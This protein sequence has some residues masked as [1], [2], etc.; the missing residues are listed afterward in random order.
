ML[1]DLSLGLFSQLSAD[2][3]SEAFL[4]MISGFFIFAIVTKNRFPKL[5]SITSN[6]LT[7]LGIL[8]TFTGVVI[9]LLEFDVD[10]ID[11]S[12]GLLLTGLKTAF[13]TSLW[14]MASSIIYKVI[15]NLY[16]P[17][18]KVVGNDPFETL[19]H[20]QLT[21]TKEIVN[22]IQGDADSSLM[23]QLQKLRTNLI[24]HQSHSDKQF[25][26]FQQ[27]LWAQM[28]EFGELLS[29]SATEQVINALKDVIT[30]FNDNLG[31][32]FGENFKRL[33]DSVQKLVIWQANYA[34][35]LESMAEKYQLGVESIQ[36]TGQAVD[37]IKQQTQAIPQHME[38]LSQVITKSDDQLQQL[39]QHLTAF[40][41]MKEKAAAAMPFIQENL[42]NLTSSISDS[43]K[44]ATDKHS[45][46]LA[47]TLNSTEQ[48]KSIST[49][50]HAQLNELSSSIKQ[51]NSSIQ[52]EHSETIK[53]LQ[54]SLLLMAD[55]LSKQLNNVVE[56]I[57]DSIVK[58]VESSVSQTAQGV[59]KQVEVLDQA[60]QQELNTTMNELGKNLTTITVKFTQDYQGLV[61]EMNKVINANR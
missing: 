21:A 43:I 14:G 36:H 34:E 40:A 13:I 17:K 42:N 53:Q 16:P 25:N 39:Q 15:L 9:G 48:F 32:Q 31:E 5:A 19:M 29:K 8:G 27:Q 51:T 52:Q 6:L 24:D 61:N 33:D 44:H 28:T 20:Q 10:N 3:I 23:S 47:N 54:Q 57:S 55:E 49:D 7:S 59:E 60:I 4:W 2:N 37:S 46:M 38:A 41:E 18:T 50:V 45:E 58:Q 22:A 30:D 1:Y 35:Q 12:I 11:G 26:A 56:T